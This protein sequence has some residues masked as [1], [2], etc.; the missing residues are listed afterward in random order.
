MSSHI[1]EGSST[2]I[3][4]PCE[5]YFHIRL[6]YYFQ[7]A[8]NIAAIAVFCFAAIADQK[9]F[10]CCPRRGYP[11]K[12]RT[13]YSYDHSRRKIDIRHFLPGKHQR[14]EVIPFIHR[15]DYK[16]LFRMKSAQYFCFPAISGAVGL[17]LRNPAVLVNQPDCGGFIR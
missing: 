5:D 6:L 11:H 2:K 13:A 17:A 15:S 12:S 14:I 7:T 3:S 9:A 16:T 10:F 1:I 8:G 4:L